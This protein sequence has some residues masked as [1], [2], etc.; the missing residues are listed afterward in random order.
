MQEA[1][2]NIKVLPQ[3]LMYLTML[4][5]AIPLEVIQNIIFRLLK[6]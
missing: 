6:K 1:F 4:T 5:K 2:S 3:I